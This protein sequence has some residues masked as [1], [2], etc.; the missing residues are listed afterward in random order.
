MSVRGVQLVLAI[1]LIT[2]CGNSDKIPEKI[3]K[4]EQMGSIL[5]DIALAEGYLESYAFQDSLVKRDSLLVTELDKILAIHKT[6]Q[7]EF[8]ESYR[9]YKDHPLLFKEVVDSVYANAQRNRE[10]IYGKRPGSP[11]LQEIKK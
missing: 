11:R 8:L 9:Y 4:K 5:F 1:F 7:Q 3:L 2:S 10:R 6:S